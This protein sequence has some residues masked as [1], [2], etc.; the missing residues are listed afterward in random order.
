MT[1]QKTTRGRRRIVYADHL[2]LRLA[3]QQIPEQLPRRIYLRA[4]E[5]FFDTITQHRVAVARACY[6]GKMR[7]MAVSFED[8]GETVALITI[9]SL[10]ERQKMNRI[11]AR[12]WIPYKKKETCATGQL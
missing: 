3:L 11:D 12:R 7:E 4:K 5:W 1:E 9:H 8:D 2:H 6:A 10:K